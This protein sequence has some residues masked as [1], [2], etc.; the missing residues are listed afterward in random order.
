MG[1]TWSPADADQTVEAVKDALA[2]GRTLE[3][4][5]RGTRRAFGRPVAADA[6]LDLSALA[7][8]VA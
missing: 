4:L 8:V 3:L 2:G 5:G 1:Q 6:V 7:G